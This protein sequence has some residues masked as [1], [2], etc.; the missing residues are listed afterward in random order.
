LYED[1]ILEG[2]W[3]VH[4]RDNYRIPFKAVHGQSNRFDFVVNEAPSDFSGEWHC[5]FEVGTPDAYAATAIFRQEKNKVTGTFLTE[6]GDYRYLEGQV[7][8]KKIYLSAF[9]GAH[10]FLFTGKI[11]TDGSI[12]GIFR[13][14]SHYTA[15]WIGSKNKSSESSLRNAY[16]L[17]KA[18]E[19]AIMF[20]FPDEE[21]RQVS[22][23]DKQFEN[24]A[25]LIQIMGTWCPNCFDETLFLTQYLS[26]KKR[27]DIALVSLCFERYKEEQKALSVIKRYKQKL[28]LQHN[29][30][31]A[32][33]FDKKEA[34]KQIPQLDTLLSYPTLLFV[35]KNNQIKAIHTGFS[36]PAT[37]VFPKF[38]EEFEANLQ[39]LIAGENIQ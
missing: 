10:A 29:L 12:A 7:A 9:D 11:M 8:G 6:T 16:T 4:Y 37:P 17:T 23:S 32:G 13:S 3:I 22:L 31:Y 21:G 20:S 38:K 24:K 27:D 14:G 28:K 33:Y 1:G 26:D 39:K 15:Q 5:T 25:K 36:G 34:L 19:N 30:L 35:D 2:D 18:K